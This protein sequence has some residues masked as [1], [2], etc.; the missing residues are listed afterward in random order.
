MELSQKFVRRQLETLQPLLCGCSLEL[1]RR[2]QEAVGKLMQTVYRKEVDFLPVPLPDIECCWAVPRQAAPDAGPILYLHGGGYVCGDLDYAKGFGSVLAAETGLSVLCPAYR[3]A[4]EH[5]FPSALEDALSCYQYLLHLG[6]SPHSIVLAGESA[7]GGLIFSL[8]LRLREL[9]LP[10]P[11]GLIGISPWTDLTL[12]GNSYGTNRERDPSMTQKQL[13]FFTECYG[14]DPKDPLLSPLW[15]DLRG[16]PP[17]L[18]FV[19]G[20]EIM[21][22]DAKDMFTQLCQAGCESKLIVGESL[23]HGYVLYGLKER[24]SDTELLASFA[25]EVALCQRN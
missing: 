4:P 18:I 11:G 16:M 19:G 2:G 3:L 21:L 14:G 13:D 1:S 10:L 17:S 24:K 23:W 9:G 5:P 15:G 12:S 8:C 20:D 22:S 25:R 7:G 6:K